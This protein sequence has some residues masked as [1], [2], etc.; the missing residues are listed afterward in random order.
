MYRDGFNCKKLLKVCGNILVLIS[1]IFLLKKIMSMDI[2]Y[3]NIF[4]KGNIVRLVPVLLIYTIQII[5]S[6]LPWS[7]I[8]KCLTGEGVPRLKSCA[9]FVKSNIMKYIPGN[10]FQYVGRTEL[11]QMSENINVTT[12]VVSVVIETGATVLAAFLIGI[13]GVSSYT[14]SLIRENRL[15]FVL[16]IVVFTAVLFLLSF[17]REKLD[18]YKK[19]KNI[20]VTKKLLGGFFVA[21]VFYIITLIIDGLMLIYIMQMIS[22]QNCFAYTKTICG[23]YGISWLA[24]YIIPGAS[25]GI[26]I[27]EALLVVLLRESMSISVITMA[28]LILRLINILSDLMAYVIV[29]GLKRVYMEK[30]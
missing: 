11:A 23:A 6:Y 27:R 16:L 28:A 24:G 15:I 13:V 22:D 30:Q 2:D 7:N 26:G 5:L 14:I 10:L 1:I 8:I 21:L 17:F 9:V 4:S 19:R 25:G 20:I 18:N 3:K 12:I 29:L